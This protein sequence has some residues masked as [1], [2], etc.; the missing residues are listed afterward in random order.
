MDEAITQSFTIARLKK[1]N[2]IRA[3]IEITNDSFAGSTTK[4]D[5]ILKKDT[6][7]T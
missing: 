1:D 4:R 6:N 5:P 7:R 2:I 3:I